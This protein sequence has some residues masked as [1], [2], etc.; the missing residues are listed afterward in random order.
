VIEEI[1][2][3]IGCYRDPDLKNTIADAVNKADIPQRIVFGIV[4]Q[5]TNE[6]FNDFMSNMSLKGNK[7]NIRYFSIDKTKGTGWARNIITKDMLDKEAYWLQIDSHTRFKKSWDTQIIDFYK[8][9]GEPHLLSAFPPHFGFEE[10]YDMYS[11]QRTVNNK[12]VVL[13]FTEM[14]SFRETKGTIPE[15]AY[16]ESITASGAFQFAENKVAKS[17]TFEQYFNPWMDQ[18]I[19]SCLAYMNGYKIIAPRDAFLWHCYYDNHIGS[20]TKW[21]ELVADDVNINGYD[22]YPFDTIKGFNTARTWQSWHDRV[23]QDIND[24]KNKK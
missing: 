18:E 5:G 6:E 9:V 10:D 20:E 8:N 14:F 23:M 24:Y 2:I 19:S 1:F 3:S 16:E 7:V 11:T 15:T 12:S 21:R 4:Y 13:E 17:L 22:M